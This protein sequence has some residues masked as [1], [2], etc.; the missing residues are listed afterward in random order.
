VPFN[1]SGDVVASDVAFLNDETSVRITGFLTSSLSSEQPALQLSAIYRD[2]SGL[3]VG[4]T[5][6][7]VESMPAGATV[8]F[9]IVDAPAPESTV[10]VTIY[11]QLGG[12]LP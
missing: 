9:A 2:G 6:G 3:I 1:P 12:Q 4:G 8:P 5:V 11:W 7:A 10:E